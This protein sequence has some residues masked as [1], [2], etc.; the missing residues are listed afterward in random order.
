MRVRW[1]VVAVVPVGVVFAEL[2][3]LVRREDAADAEKHLG[4]GLFERG[5]GV[6]DLVDLGGSFC[7]VDGIGV[8]QGLKEELLLFEGSMQVDELDAALDEDVF[9][10]LLLVRREADA[11][12][13]FGV[14]P[15]HAEALVAHIAVAMVVIVVHHAGAAG[16][17]TILREGHGG[18][19]KDEGRK[20]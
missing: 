16:R 17:W 18:D 9:H 5:A 11:G 4:I 3:P 19:E 12:G 7:L 8:H 20:E 1:A 13:D 2:G 6:G 10:L 15:P 14:L